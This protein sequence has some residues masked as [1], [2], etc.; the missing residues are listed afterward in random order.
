M[1]AKDFIFNHRTIFL[2]LVCLFSY[3][4]LIQAEIGGGSGRKLTPYVPDK[5]VKLSDVILV[6][7]L[8]RENRTIKSLNIRDSHVQQYGEKVSLMYTKD[9]QTGEGENYYH[10]IGETES[11][12]ADT[13]DF[14]QLKS[15]VL[16]RVERRMLS[17]D[18]ALI[19]VEQFPNVEPEY[20]LSKEPSYSELVENHTLK[21]RLW[22]TLKDED[23]RELCLAGSFPTHMDDTSDVLSKLSEI[24]PNS[25]VIFDYGLTKVEVQ[26]KKIWIPTIWW[27][28]PSVVKDESY[29]YKSMMTAN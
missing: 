5:E 17:S 22:I 4:I 20:L 3:T 16:L 14:S 23:G 12:I 7:N 9:D 26:A 8:A 27:A 13:V 19:E 18:R 29:P 1:K 15:F 24:E 21:K 28:I 6:K 10:F 11:G 25:E 2:S